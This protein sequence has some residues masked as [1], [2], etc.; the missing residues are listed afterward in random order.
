MSLWR[1]WLIAALVCAGISFF[2][3]QLHA[4]T[5]IGVEGGAAVPLVHGNGTPYML[6][7]TF[8]TEKL[9]FVLSGR[10][11]LNG[12]RFTAGGVNVD[13]WLRK[14]QIG[15]SIFNFYYGPGFTILYH[16]EVDADNHEQSTGVF[17]AP[18]VFAGMN[19]MLT[20]FTELYM[21]AAVEPGVVFDEADGFIFRMNLPL[22]VGLRFWF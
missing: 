6:G 18:R 2:P 14:I 16:P 8:K 1:G 20:S 12:S 19:M 4:G 9:P 5:G 3:A 17:V 22:S 10:A 21:Q 15:Y 13:M 11:Q 7:L